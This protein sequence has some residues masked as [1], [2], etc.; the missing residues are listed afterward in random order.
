MNVETTPFIP[1][2]PSPVEPQESEIERF[3]Q[4]RAYMSGTHANVQVGQVWENIN[5]DDGDDFGLQQVLITSIVEG[6]ATGINVNIDGKGARSFLGESFTIPT[7]KLNLAEDGSGWRVRSFV[8]DLDVKGRAAR[9]YRLPE[10]PK[11]KV[12][13]PKPLAKKKEG[14]KS[15]PKKITQRD[16]DSLLKPINASGTQEP[17]FVSPEDS[18][19]S[20]NTNR[21]IPS[22][23][24]SWR[25][26][27][28]G[29]LSTDRDKRTVQ[30]FTALTKKDEGDTPG[31]SS[32]TDIQ[33]IN[34]A[35]KRSGSRLNDEHVKFLKVN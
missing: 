19:P 20:A 3:A 1:L 16:V 21:S 31:D 25:S 6:I 30:P 32:P 13:K 4:I 8:I 11:P 10:K 33:R 18:K 12:V 2:A 22:P 23:S 24:D 14:D 29:V 9:S 26:V 34:D 35:F 5:P 28:S 17:L 27:L 7:R 15:A